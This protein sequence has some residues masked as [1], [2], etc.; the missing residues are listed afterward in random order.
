MGAAD[1]ANERAGD[2]DQEGGL[3]SCQ[4]AREN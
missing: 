2:I 3:D 1:D 4:V